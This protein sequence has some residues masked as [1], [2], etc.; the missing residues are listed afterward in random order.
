MKPGDRFGRLVYIGPTD[1]TNTAASQCHALR[2]DCG[3]VALAT[4]RALTRE[5]RP[6]LECRR[7]EVRTRAAAIKARAGHPY[8]RNRNLRHE[9]QD[10]FKRAVRRGEIVSPGKCS[11]CGTT[12]GRICGHHEDYSK[13][14]EVVWLCNSCH[15]ARHGELGTMLSSD[16]RDRVLR[17]AAQL[18]PEAA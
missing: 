3:V 14:L 5:K 10:T 4:E 17:L 8:W 15:G 2:C 11:R 9:A 7:C 1:R 16:Q 18:G 13:P 6:A 12:E